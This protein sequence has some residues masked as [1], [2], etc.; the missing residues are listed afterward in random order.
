MNRLIP[1]VVWA[2]VGDVVTGGVLVSAAIKLHRTGGLRFLLRRVVRQSLDN[3][4]KGEETR[5][6]SDREQ[7]A[8][9]GN[10]TSY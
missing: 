5:Q 8:R 2:C 9:R 6:P 4:A 3:G 1:V 10:R 7:N